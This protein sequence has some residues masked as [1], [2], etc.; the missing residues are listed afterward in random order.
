M[1]S[2]TRLSVDGYGARRAGSFAGRGESVSVVSGAGYYDGIRKR[3]KRK[4]LIIDGKTYRV[5]PYEEK[6]LVQAYIDRL[7]DEKQE[8][9]IEVKKQRKILKIAKST[10]P[11]KSELAPPPQVIRV[12]SR[13]SELLKSIQELEIKHREAIQMKRAA[14]RAIDDEDAMAL[15]IGMWI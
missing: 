12:E 11:R 9:E 8:A 14:E 15:I 3:R 4:T 5:S 10:A 2:I 1:A 13:I 6:Q 7:N